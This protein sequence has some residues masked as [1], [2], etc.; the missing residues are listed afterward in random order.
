MKLSDSTC[1]SAKPRLKPYKLADGHGLYLYVKPDG[2]RT[3]RQKYYH[4]GKEGLLTHG[5]YPVVGLADAR[6]KRED[7]RRLLA[8]GL[9]PATAKKKAKLEAVEKQAT[10][11]KAVALE[12]HSIQRASWSAEHAAG[13]LTRLEKDLFPLLG[14]QPLAD[15]SPAELLRTLRRI[16]QRAAFY[17]AGRAR[18]LAGSIFRYGRVTGKCKHDPATDLRGA[19]RSKR[20]QHFAA[21]DK[22]T[23]PEFLA[24]LNA[25]QA[26]LYPRTINAIKL[27]MLTFQRPG[28]IRQARWDEIDFEKALWTIPAHKMKMRRSHLVPLSKQAMEVLKA[29]KLEAKALNSPWVFPSQIKPK[30]PMSDGTVNCALKRLGYSQEMTAHGFRALARTTIRE[31]LKIDADVIERQLAHKASGPL[32]E[33]YDRAQF[34]EERTLMMQHWADYLDTCQIYKPTNNA[35]TLKLKEVA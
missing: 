33:A 3:W 11:F 30:Q 17:S 12:W 34:I 14:D 19:L 28:E 20:T 8:D 32:G 2:T 18:A 7:A 24:A 9:N 13:I 35:V 16:E 23:L 5:P 26:R 29:Q 10:T 25:N 15:I 21:L 31:D 27:S 6:Q 4:H 1:R 22:K